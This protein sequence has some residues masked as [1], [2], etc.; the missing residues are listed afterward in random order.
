M[1]G[2]SRVLWAL[3]PLLPGLRPGEAFWPLWREGLI[4]GTDP[5]DPEYW[6]D[7]GDFDQRMV[8]MAVLGVGFAW[9]RSAFLGR[10]PLPAGAPLPVA[11]ADQCLCMPRNNWRFFRILVNLGLRQAGQPMDEARM[12]GGSGPDGKPLRG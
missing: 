12:R 1:G 6:G 4:H 3:V 8:E 7:I 5:Q 10:L 11:G 9:Y 2:F